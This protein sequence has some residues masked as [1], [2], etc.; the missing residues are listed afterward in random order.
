M[1]KIVPSFIEEFRREYR[2]V[3][4]GVAARPHR[5][6]KDVPWDRACCPRCRGHKWRCRCPAGD[7]GQKLRKGC[8][9][10]SP[11][12][13]CR[14]CEEERI[15]RAAANPLPPPSKQPQLGKREKGNVDTPQPLDCSAHGTKRAA[16]AVAD[17]VAVIAAGERGSRRR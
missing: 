9:V 2:G 6:A 13:D 12:P 4:R 7:R 16:S 15:A 5:S 3:H 8:S 11:P 10:I 14:Q 17:A 1:K